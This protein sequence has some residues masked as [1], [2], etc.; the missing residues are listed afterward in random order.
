MARLARKRA[1]VEERA[2]RDPEFAAWRKEMRQNL[3]DR[4]AREAA[5]AEKARSGRS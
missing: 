1:E 4:L 5:E 2:L 3:E